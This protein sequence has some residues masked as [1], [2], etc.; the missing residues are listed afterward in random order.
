MDANATLIRRAH[1]KY[2]AGD[3]EALLEI[4]DPDL[5]WTFL[6]PSEADPEPRVCHGRHELAHALERQREQG[7]RTEL[8]EVVG[9]GDTVVIVTHTPGIDALRARKADDRNV[10][11]LTL[12]GGRVVAI[13]ACHDRREGMESAGFT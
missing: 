12:R 4:V 9:Q 10:D 5:E 6:D 7:L 13:R 3:L 11:V 2:A 8:D 1:T